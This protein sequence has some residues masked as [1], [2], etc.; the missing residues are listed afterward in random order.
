MKLFAVVDGF[1]SGAALAR[2]IRVRGHDC[3]NVLSSPDVP[4]VF[5]RS[6]NRALFSREL[7]ASDTVAAELGDISPDFIVAGAESGVIL[8]DE[9]SERLGLLTNGTRRSQAR[10]DK[11]LMAETVRSAGIRTAEQYR[12]SDATK[13]AEWARCLDAFPVVVKPLN[14]CGADSVFVCS[15]PGEV[16]EGAAR[17][18]GHVNQIGLRNKDVLVQEFIFGTEYIVNTVSRD[19]RTFVCD[20]WR[21]HKERVKGAS[22][23]SCV[24]ELL[25][26][27]GDI[28]DA[29]SEYAIGV[30][31]ALQILHGPAH[32]EIMMT[33][34][35]PVLIEVGS[36]LQG[37]TNPASIREALGTD[38]LALT[39]QAYL[40]PESF[41]CRIDQ[42]Y[43]FRKAMYHS[44]MVSPHGG[45][46]IALPRMAELMNLT[47]VYHTNMRV[48]IGGSIERTTGLFS[49]P[50]I[51]DF[52]HQDARKVA[53]DY[54]TF[55]AM[56]AD[57]FYLV[58]YP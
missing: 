5:R 52:I 30:L 32:F 58:K 22:Y 23:I 28:Q 12:T 37:A 48:D 47:T 38:Q 2:E 42:P 19:G 15:T 4:E 55:R 53:D 31:D 54:A 13:A 57:N 7:I 27:N 36:R 50:G 6:Y 41:R 29:L 43:H 51:V 40:E 49:S 11:Y 1:S 24:E 56:E 26:R 21:C 35:G 44:F 8:A 25:P 45:K 17:I 3:I 14:S 34:S 10:R 20:I 33:R 39:L 18:L 46:L 16:V 9:L